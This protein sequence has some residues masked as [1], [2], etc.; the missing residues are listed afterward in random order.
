MLNGW[1]DDLPLVGDVRGD[2][3]F[4][5]IELVKDRATRQEFSRDECEQLI[6]GYLSPRLFEE[7]LVCRADDRGDPVIQFA[8]PLIAG[9]EEFAEIDRIVRHRPHRRVGR[10]PSVT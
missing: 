8:P 4:W 7:G 1:R 2:G 9:P 3:Y 5:A 10:V 6:R